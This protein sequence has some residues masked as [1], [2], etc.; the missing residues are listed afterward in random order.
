[1]QTS[2][3]DS[4][5]SSRHTMVID[6]DESEDSIFVSIT[7]STSKGKQ[8]AVEED[9]PFESNEASSTD[10]QQSNKLNEEQTKAPFIDLAQ[11][12]QNLL[13]QVRPVLDKNPQLVEHAN[14][15]MDQILQN[16]P[17]D[18]DI[19]GQGVFNASNC[20]F[21]D[22]RQQND[23]TLDD[24]NLS[25]KLRILHSMGF[26]EDDEKNIELLKKYSGNIDKVVEVLITIQNERIEKGLNF[27]PP[28]N[29]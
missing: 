22:Q 28:T 11:R 18:I 3:I 17:V 20:P 23:Q 26:W 15:I 14:N 13:E 1:S 29:E 21:M 10:Q 9:T 4:E 19:V 16:I 5:P 24:E 27:Q 12:F 6:E 2:I 7:S 8:R 25:E